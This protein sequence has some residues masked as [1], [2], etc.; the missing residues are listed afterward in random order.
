[1]NDITYTHSVKQWHSVY[2]VIGALLRRQFLHSTKVSKLVSK[3]LKLKWTSEWRQK[4][5]CGTELLNCIVVVMPSSPFFKMPSPASALDS[6]LCRRRSGHK[7]WVWH[8]NVA[9][10]SADLLVLV[11][12]LNV[13]FVILSS[14]NT[15]LRASIS[16][17]LISCLFSLDSAALLMLK[18][19]P[20]YL[21]G[22]I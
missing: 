2:Q 12:P 3:I 14:D 10:F 6:N 21:F 1:M 20:C 22:Q 19:Q 9:Y 13:N 15:N 17:C 7:R 18:Q 11:W 4:Q 16:V 8:C 5:I